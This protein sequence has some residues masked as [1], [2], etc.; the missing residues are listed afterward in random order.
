MYTVHYVGYL[1]KYIVRT[2][3]M[4]DSISV[5]RYVRTFCT[6]I[7]ILDV[8]SATP[9]PRCFESPACLVHTLRARLI[10]FRNAHIV[11]EGCACDAMRVGS[12]LAAAAPD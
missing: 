9:L 4:S 5:L 3:S 6:Q 8:Y 10:P 1:E 11:A 12:F 7:W 2:H